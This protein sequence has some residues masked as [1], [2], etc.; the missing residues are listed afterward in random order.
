[1]RPSHDGLL[2]QIIN[3]RQRHP[4]SQLHAH[5][6]KVTKSL[7]QIQLKWYFQ[8]Y[9]SIDRHDRNTGRITS[10]CLVI[11]R[12]SLHTMW[13]KK[14]LEKWCAQLGECLLVPDNQPSHSVAWWIPKW[15][16]HRWWCTELWIYFAILLFT[17]NINPSLPGFRSWA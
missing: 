6:D 9:F 14:E 17:G 12:W 3:Y 1:M 7:L 11:T 5:S 4:S 16:K 13:K 10:D 8:S 2:F 15:I